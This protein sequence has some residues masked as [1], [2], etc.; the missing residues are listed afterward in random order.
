MTNNGANEPWDVVITSARQAS[1]QMA[2]DEVLA[3]A[4]WQGRRPPTLRLY[5]WHHPG[6][7]IGRH[8]HPA[9][10]LSQGAVRRITGGHAIYHGDELTLSLALP[11]GHPL[12]RP[13]IQA[14][15]LNVSQ[16]LHLALTRLG[17]TPNTT[18]ATD[19]ENGARQGV[20]AC[21]DQPG[22]GE[23][24][25]GDHKLMGL[26][27]RLCPDGLLAQA[28]IPL[29]APKGT[30]KPQPKGVCDLNPHITWESLAAALIT[31]VGDCFRVTL[32]P[33]RLSRAES[34]RAS[35]LA[36]TRYAPLGH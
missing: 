2:I 14:T 23:A 33:S 7:T 6:V 34:C 11:A 9:A 29:G 8:Q 10:P 13:T 19:T 15:Y 18:K 1:R 28:S 32:S 31:A 26:A 12:I 17:L 20:F 30:R 16:P 4:V 35:Q 24:M 27:Q 3:N 36:H 22:F 25:H 5:H 21:F